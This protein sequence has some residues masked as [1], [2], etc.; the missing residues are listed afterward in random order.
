MSRAAAECRDAPSDHAAPESPQPPCGELRV[1]TDIVSVARIRASLERFGER[2]QLRLFTAAER[3][4][5]L[6]MGSR[7]AEHF[8]ARFAAKEAVLKVLRPASSTPD[9]RGIEI[10]RDPTGWCSVVLHGAAEATARAQ[11]IR[12]IAVSLTHDEG[13]A[14]STA[15]A[16]AERDCRAGAVT[17]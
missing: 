3:E 9:W 2:F 12:E 4:Y 17:S 10:R 15:L 8:A 1:G 6:R 5:C 13:F 16:V 11:G 14:A 7:A